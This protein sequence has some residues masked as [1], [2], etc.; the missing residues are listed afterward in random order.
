MA[1]GNQLHWWQEE[2]DSAA[3]RERVRSLKSDTTAS[4][5]A[6]T[7]R[8]DTVVETVTVEAA[9]ETLAEPIDIGEE[10]EAEAA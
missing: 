7:G 2:L 3:A 1:E 6:I 10:L 8:S 4:P 5:A 9:E